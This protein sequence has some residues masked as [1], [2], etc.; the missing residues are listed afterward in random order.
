[1]NPGKPSLEEGIKT[2]KYYI[3]ALT[4][5]QLPFLSVGARFHQNQKNFSAFTVLRLEPLIKF[6]NTLERS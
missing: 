3:T 1:M 5:G 4:L 6:F 2:T